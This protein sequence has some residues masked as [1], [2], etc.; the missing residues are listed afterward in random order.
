MHVIDHSLA[1]PSPAAAALVSGS[2]RSR[3]EATRNAAGFSH[4]NATTSRPANCRSRSKGQGRGGKLVV[5]GPAMKTQPCKAVCP[6][7]RAMGGQQA[8]RLH[9]HLATVGVKMLGDQA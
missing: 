2:P 8:G 5:L 9:A 1:S 6:Q 4:G 3:L 7:H